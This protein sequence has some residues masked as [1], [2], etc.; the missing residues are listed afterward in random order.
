MILMRMKYSQIVVIAGTV[1][2]NSASGWSQDSIVNPNS[3][4]VFQGQEEGY[5]RG[6]GLV[7]ELSRIQGQ[8]GQ[9]SEVWK[10]VKNYFPEI[11]AF[12]DSQNIRFN[13]VSQNTPSGEIQV[14]H[15]LPLAKQS[16]LNELAFELYHKNLGLKLIYDPYHL[17][18]IGAGA[19]FSPKDNSLGISHR[20]LLFPH[21]NESF[22]HELVHAQEF[23]FRLKGLQ[24]PF[25]GVVQ[26]GEDTLGHRISEKNSSSYIRHM[27][28]EEVKGYMASLL[29][30]SHTFKELSAQ[31][32][33]RPQDLE[34]LLEQIHHVAEVG[35]AVAIQAL[36]VSER[37]QIRIQNSKNLQFSS[38]RLTA[39][40]SPDGLFRDVVRVSVSIDS[41]SRE[42]NRG[43]GFNVPYPEH[44]QV[45]FSLVSSVDWDSFQLGDNEKLKLSFQKNLKELALL[46]TEVS[47]VFDDFLQAFP[48][49]LERV[50]TDQVNFQ[51]L[52]E[53]T[54][55][56]EQ[57]TRLFSSPAE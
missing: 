26:L 15:I 39:P 25:H 9:P 51:K 10:T 37:V 22:K 5:A 54:E 48:Y 35:K 50:N 27:S 52:R 4:A 36:D 55:R 47:R 3:Q 34:E 21:M 44:T 8:W 42:F 23:C 41:Y 46:S 17:A 20:S 45:S 19:F 56:I 40:E 24:T 6:Q 2:L 16:V 32:S 14:F 7:E 11:R 49:F 1:L 29:F 18:S 57:F 33:F 30:L 28:F 31:P 38:L 43:I 12:L 13:E 53:A